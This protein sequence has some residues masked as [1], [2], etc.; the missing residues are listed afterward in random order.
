MRQVFVGI[1]LATAVASPAAWAEGSCEPIRLDWIAGGPFNPTPKDKVD[2]T[3]CEGLGYGERAPC[4]ERHK[5]DGKQHAYV[6]VH[7]QGDYGSCTFQTVAG[8]LNYGK[9]MSG[10]TPD[11]SPEYLASQDCDSLLPGAMH[12]VTSAV[13]CYNHAGSCARPDLAE[14]NNGGALTRAVREAMK[15]AM[16]GHLTPSSAMC[17]AV[18]AGAN[19]KNTRKLGS[20]LERIVS[21][22]QGDGQEQSKMSAFM[23]NSALSK[24][25]KS[26]REEYYTCRAEQEVFRPLCKDHL[27]PVGPNAGLKGEE[28]PAPVGAA[29]KRAR[30]R[31]LTD[32]MEKNPHP[33]EIRLA[34]ANALLNDDGADR[35]SVGHAVLLE[36][37]SRMDGECGYWIRNSWGSEC[38]ASKKP[39]V[40]CDPTRPGLVWV[41]EKALTGPDGFTHDMDLSP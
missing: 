39:T 40:K 41:A 21:K 18:T 35:G 2:G 34:H 4:L 37:R 29:G 22:M 33:I 7:D 27:E 14:V 10:T 28:L 8:V 36:G 17:E 31:A 6:P 11:V 23:S 3:I 20:E 26:Q 15:T 9:S 30:L 19:D 1:A 13:A 25:S 32:E 38:P 24:A 12:S 5:G 16:T